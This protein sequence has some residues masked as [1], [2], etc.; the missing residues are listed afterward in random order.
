MADGLADG[1]NLWAGR[2]DRGG[3]E[4]VGNEFVGIG[5]LAGWL[6]VSGQAGVSGRGGVQD[7]RGFG[8]P[9]VRAGAAGALFAY[10]AAAGA[11]S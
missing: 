6:D 2:N 11:W 1:R 8:Q 4:F 5:W 10:A 7:R 3:T 9:D